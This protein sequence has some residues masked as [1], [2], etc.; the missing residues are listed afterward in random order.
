MDWHWG[1]NAG[2]KTKYTLIISTPKEF[3]K[4]V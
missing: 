4:N 2:Y 3:I 1:V